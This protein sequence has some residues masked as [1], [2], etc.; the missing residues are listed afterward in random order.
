[1]QERS[2]SRTGHHW[3]R[4]LAAGGM[5]SYYRSLFE[6][7]PDAIL[8]EDLEGRVLDVNRAACDLHEM[9]REELVG[10]SEWELVPEEHREQ[11][12]E[13]RR[14]LVGGTVNRL[15][16]Y[17]L[18]RSGRSLPVSIH[19]G[20]IEDRQPP[21]LLIHVRD[22]SD[23]V[24][25]EQALHESRAILEKAQS[26]GQVGSWIS[27]P[28]PH[29][30]LTWSREACRIF[31]VQPAEFDGRVE[32][33]FKLV[34]PAD[35][36]RVMEASRLALC[37]SRSYDIEHRI[38][39]AD[40]QVRWVLQQADVERD[41]EGRPSRM[42]GVVQDVTER[43]LADEALRASENRFRTIFDS[44]PE[45]VK[46]LDAGGRLLE[47]N[48]AG[49]AMMGAEIV[50]QVAGQ[51][52]IPLVVPEHREAFGSLLARVI[53]GQSG[54]LSF[55][56]ISLTG[57]R[58]WMDTHASPLRNASGVVLAGLFV[59][60]DI[61]SQMLADRKLRDSEERFRALVENGFEGINIIDLQGNVLY[62]SPASYRM[63]GYRSDENVGQD[64]LRFLHPDDM[65]TAFHLL[66]RLAAEPQ[67]VFSPVLRLRHQNGSWR[68]VEMKARNLLAHPAVRGIVVN[69]RDITDRKLAEEKLATQQAD[70]LHASRLS[71]MGQMVATMSHEISQPLAALGN[72]SAACTK[73]LETGP[74]A[75]P[76]LFHGY[77]HEISRQAQ[78]AAAIV[79]R[80]RAFGAKSTP[81]PE[82]C[83]L[84]WLLRDS[85][86]LVASELRRH[87][88]N[89][90]WELA[91]PAPQIPVDRVQFQQVVVNLLTNACDALLEVEPDR[92]Q[93][94]V[95]SRVEQEAAVIDIIDRGIGLPAEMMK[96]LF[97]PFFTTK[98]DGM[99]LGLSIC[100]EIVEDHGGQIEAL[101][102]GEGATFR[103]RMP[104][105]DKKPG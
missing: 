67:Q 32:T 100:R 68:W 66:R 34:Y 42:V 95:R 43:K 84:N 78:R 36:P 90:L 16:G 6:N 94:I 54:S 96:S 25:T 21:I 79:K 88:V 12:A 62:A 85:V 74:P 22:I 50:E 27:D 82:L 7:A 80:L 44:E 5:E 77:V 48:R 29:G 70:L 83:D 30:R 104:L 61:T 10:R 58:R 24:Q 69:W 49:L 105:A 37:G 53:S 76:E 102:N 75:S 35:L 31:G 26:V 99:G 3:D 19:V 64:G 65:E 23:H 55:E 18:T 59:T 63:L 4:G 39:R 45:C 47:M 89:V 71:T 91:E 101:S 8:V 93:V 2:I 98:P 56:M 33:F 46:L 103:V 72:F 15:N 41:A 11:A 73:M 97:Q 92:R 20:R 14:R 13:D 51:C 86:E 81:E 1:M 87:G 9:P 28:S 60:R 52:V 17:R 38:V 57:K 40:G